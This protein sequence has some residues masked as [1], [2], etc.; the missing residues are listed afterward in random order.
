MAAS[1]DFR[2]LLFRYTTDA[3]RFVLV[4]KLLMH[5]RD[6][7]AGPVV[8]LLHGAFSSLHTY[9]E[10]AK[11]LKRH[12]RVI[13]LD[14]PGFGLTGPTPNNEYHLEE[15]L[16]YLKS[17]FAIMGLETFVI[18]GSSLGGWLA[19]EYALRYPEKIQKLILIDSAGFLDEASI[20]LPFKLARAPIFG[21]VIK[22]VVRRAVLEQFVKQVYFDQNKVTEALVNRYYDLFTREGNPEAFLRLVNS[23]HRDNTTAL[24]RI[25]IPTLIMWGREDMWIPVENAYRFHRL[26]PMPRLKIYPQV[27]HLPME[28]IPE[29]TVWDFMQ[30]IEGK[31]EFATSFL[32]ERPLGDEVEETKE[33]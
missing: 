5:Y 11:H 12:Y 19:W 25:Q 4:D 27:G 14:L 2:D 15:H 18:A 16:R 28:E 20:P 7:G 1:K 21:R 33:D 31:G 23:P 32:A 6:E 9:N 10:W 8:V 26:L 13:R 17:F 30:F 24:V 29:E 22:Y 3:S